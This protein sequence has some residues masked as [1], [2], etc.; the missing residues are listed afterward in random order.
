ML[1]YAH[2]H[3]LPLRNLATLPPVMHS[4]TLRFAACLALAAALVTGCQSDAATPAGGAQ[5]IAPDVT[6]ALSQLEAGRALD[7]HAARSDA[8]GRLEVYVYVTDVAAMTVQSLAASGLEDAVASPPLGLVQGWI[9]PKDIATL[10]ASPLVIRI[11]LPR[12][13]RHD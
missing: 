8:A 9:A 6:A 10:A 3:R 13:A 11:T 5:K 4:K 12:Y 2:I 7:P 1:G